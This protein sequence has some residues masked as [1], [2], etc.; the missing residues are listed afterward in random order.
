LSSN[1]KTDCPLLRP[2]DGGARAL[3]SASRN[4]MFL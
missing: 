2:L 3:L 4:E 1:A